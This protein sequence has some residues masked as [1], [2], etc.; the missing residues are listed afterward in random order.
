[1]IDWLFDWLI[2]WLADWLTDSF[3]YSI[4]CLFIHSFFYSLTGWLIDWHTRQREDSRASSDMT[5]VTR[6]RSS[7]GAPALHLVSVENNSVS[8]FGLMLCTETNRNIIIVL[9]NLGTSKGS[10]KS[11]LIRLGKGAWEKN[12][13]GRLLAQL[14]EDESENELVKDK[15]SLA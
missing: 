3:I 5:Y 1:L 14:E 12:A 2:D 8:P 13:E 15:W 6:S 4:I 7:C 10:G 9:I 11:D